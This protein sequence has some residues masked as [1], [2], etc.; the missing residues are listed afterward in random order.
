MTR[1]VHSMGTSLVDVKTYPLREGTN[2]HDCRLLAQ[3]PARRRGYPRRGVHP[4]LA[5]LIRDIAFWVAFA[6]MVVLLVLALWWREE[7]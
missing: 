7:D 2:P 4:G 5:H 3:D 6:V 1:I